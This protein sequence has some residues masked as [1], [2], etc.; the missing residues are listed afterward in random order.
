MG[1]PSF[2]ES[3]HWKPER[4]TRITTVDR[5]SGELRAQIDA[6][7]FFAFHHVNAFEDDGEVRCGEDGEQPHPTVQLTGRALRLRA[8]PRRV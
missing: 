3:Y 1:R 5:A 7:P 6:E 2:N 4:G 8:P